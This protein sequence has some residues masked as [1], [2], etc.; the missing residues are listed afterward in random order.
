MQEDA[1]RVLNGET[2]F[3]ENEETEDDP[4]TGAAEETG[5]DEEA[6]VVYITVDKKE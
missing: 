5:D 1:Q 3:L 2:A 6:S 4:G